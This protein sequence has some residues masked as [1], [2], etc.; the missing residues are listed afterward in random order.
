MA[1]DAWEVML[2]RI[3]K[4]YLSEDSAITAGMP[5]VED[6]PRYDM[7]H[8]GELVRPSVE[9]LGARQPVAHK[10]LVQVLIE[11][12]VRTM[13][14]DAA[15]EGGTAPALA[16]RWT[17]AVRAHVSD[18]DTFVAYL[19]TAYTLEERT[20]WRILRLTL[21]NA[22]EVELNAETRAREEKV[23][24]VVWMEIAGE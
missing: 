10:R 13:G 19:V 11:I 9:V 20:G 4:G 8:V 1:T 14:P 2:S 21:L 7:E 22:G 17:Q 12:T 3:F 15:G 23:S 5:A 24:V 18:V 16:A 6:A